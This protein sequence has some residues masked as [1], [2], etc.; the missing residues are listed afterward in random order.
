[1]KQD[2]QLK[3]E[4]IF[5]FHDSDKKQIEQWSNE[6]IAEQI[7]ILRKDLDNA[8]K[9]CSV[10]VA[11]LKYLDSEIMRYQDLIAKEKYDPYQHKQWLP[12]IQTHKNIYEMIGYL[13]LLQ[14][15]AMTTI[16][17]LLQAKSDT[18]RI[19]LCKHAYTI[20]YETVKNNLFQK[21][22]SGIKQ[23]PDELKGNI[24]KPFWDNI[25]SILKHIT[26]LEEAK[27]I[28]NN[29]DA[30]KCHSFATQISAYKKCS[31][32]QSVLNLNILIKIV[33]IVR[34]YMDIINNNMNQ[35]YDRYKAD[36]KERVKRMEVILDELKR[37]SK[38]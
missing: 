2:F 38:N 17:G 3:I 25:K 6:E 22:S 20:V 21:I 36:M 18:E 30:H 23:Y 13:S 15:D 32:S 33:D 24:Y 11:L 19:M 34:E 8:G 12:I 14:M 1:M 7:S 29:I 4:Q 5:E 16:I 35:M 26:N 27:E 9:K 28:R 31:W 10:C 37:L